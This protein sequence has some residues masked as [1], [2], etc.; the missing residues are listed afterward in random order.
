MDTLHYEKLAEAFFL[1][2]TTGLNQ[3]NLIYNPKAG[4]YV[5]GSVGG[6][7][8]AIVGGVAGFF[9]GGFGGAVMG[10]SLGA[11]IGNSFSKKK[12]KKEKPRLPTY[13]FS[14]SGSSNLAKQGEVI[15]IVYCDTSTNPLGGVIFSG[16]LIANKVENHGD[17]GY[18]YLAL[19]ISMGKIGSIDF[20]RFLV[21]S[22]LSYFYYL[23]DFEFSLLRGLPSNYDNAPQSNFSIANSNYF[24]HTI[25]PTSFN[26]LGVNLMALSKASGSS[27]GLVAPLSLDSNQVRYSGLTGLYSTNNDDNTPVLPNPE[28]M[29]PAGVVGIVSPD[30]IGSQ[31]GV[32]EFTLTTVGK[33]FFAGFSTTRLFED[34]E[35]GVEVVGET[36]D[37]GATNRIVTVGFGGAVPSDPEQF[38]CPIGTRIK[39]ELKRI[40]NIKFGVI[41]VDREIAVSTPL[42]W[43][44][45]MYPMIEFKTVPSSVKLDKIGALE[46]P[47]SPVNNTVSNNAGQDTMTITVYEDEKNSLDNFAL[48]SP[49]QVYQVNGQEFRV[50][51]KNASTRKLLC[52][53]SIPV[54]DENNIFRVWKAKYSS[55][56]PC[57][58]LIINFTGLLW[59]KPK[60]ETTNSSKKG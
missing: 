52:T 33:R 1:K 58:D 7:I 38:T 34:F 22:Q 35:I 6:W 54:T 29:N 23:G 12:Q 56:K 15:P 59:S 28:S 31:G 46:V 14:V 19:A 41:H 50:L 51:S 17:A 30:R 2:E 20:T 5:N 9:V 8:G 21:N 53:P 44:D 43:A 42:A 3:S 4:D 18:I 24:G 57:N 47:R 60:P 40:N 37:E 45:V 32:I 27:A 36:G 48:F 10:A 49:A 25:S 55:S 16:K 26:T 39:I 13:T 11:S